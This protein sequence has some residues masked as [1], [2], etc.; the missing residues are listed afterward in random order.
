MR[1]ASRTAGVTGFECP[2]CGA[3]I[4]NETMQGTVTMTPPTCGVF[5]KPVEMEQIYLGADAFP[6]EAEEE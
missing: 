6:K 5:H 1:G 3:Q 2:R 4:L